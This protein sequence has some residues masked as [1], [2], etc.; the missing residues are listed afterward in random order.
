[1]ALEFDPPDA[2]VVGEFD[3]AQLGVGLDAVASWRSES[4]DAGGLTRI[5]WGTRGDWIEVRWQESGTRVGVEPPRRACASTWGPRH[6]G[7][8]PVDVL[9]VPLLARI[10][11]AHGGRL[12]HDGRAGFTM[13]L[14]WP[15][16]P[17]ANGGDRA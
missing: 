7:S 4:P 9:A 13:I 12:Q 11:A 16:S 14:Q 10:V 3:P 5:G 1:V 6:A 17:G 2:P 8:R 15:Q